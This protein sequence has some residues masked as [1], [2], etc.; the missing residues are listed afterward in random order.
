M[1][2]GPGG[3]GGEMSER[4]RF[5]RCRTTLTLITRTLCEFFVGMLRTPHSLDYLVRIGEVQLSRMRPFAFFFRE[6]LA[7]P[8]H[9]ALEINPSPLE[10]GEQRS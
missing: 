5:M 2:V 9:S 8:I 6:D 7:M 4:E 3:L 1:T 10:R